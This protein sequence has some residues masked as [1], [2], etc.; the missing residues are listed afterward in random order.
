[1]LRFIRVYLV[2]RKKIIKIS[3]WIRAADYIAVR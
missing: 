2:K 1:M 3:E